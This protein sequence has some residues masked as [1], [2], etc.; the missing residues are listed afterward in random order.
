MTQPESH[1]SEEQRQSATDGTVAPDEEPFVKQHLAQC[2]ACAVDVARLA[3]LVAVARD[4]GADQASPD[5]LWPA[6]RDRIEGA[7]VV[8]LSVTAGEPSTRR[9][10]ARRSVAWIGAA[11]AAAAVVFVLGRM[12]GRFHFP[13]EAAPVVSAG[14]ADIAGIADSSRAYADQARIL[15]NRLLLERSLVRPEALAA[16]ER[17]LRVVDSAIAELDAAATRDPNNPVLRRLLVASYR[18][19]VDILKRVGNAE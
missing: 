3:K 18:E 11:A 17:D 2:H 6:I 7:K 19:K 5:D 8:P 9:G 4:A 15:F 10:R 13:G 12:S 14:G 1:L 16:I